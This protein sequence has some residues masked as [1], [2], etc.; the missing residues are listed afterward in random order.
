MN[1]RKTYDPAGGDAEILRLLNE[2]R[3]HWEAGDAATTSELAKVE[4]D[5]GR[6]LVGKVLRVK[7]SGFFGVAAKLAYVE[8]DQRRGQDW[9]GG[10][11]VREMLSSAHR[12]MQ[13]VLELYAGGAK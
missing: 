13:R 2:S 6:D 12:D 8:A 7:A 10:Y 1:R 4:Y 9:H 11:R 3:R 5:A